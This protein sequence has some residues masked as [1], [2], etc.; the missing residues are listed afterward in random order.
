MKY[1]ITLITMLY[2][3]LL[4]ISVPLKDFIE[5]VIIILSFNITLEILYLIYVVFILF[6]K[7][8]IG[9]INSLSVFTFNKVDFYYTKYYYL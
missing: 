1:A 5:I 4:L 9:Y 7:V 6:F 2:S 8:L 3:K